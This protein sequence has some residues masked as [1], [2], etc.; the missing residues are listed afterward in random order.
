[1]VNFY[2]ISS[3]SSASST[4]TK[5]EKLVSSFMHSFSH[6][7]I[8]GDKELESFVKLI[9]LKIRSI[10]YVNQRCKKPNCSFRDS[11]RKN[12]VVYIVVGDK[13]NLPIN[14]LNFAGEIK[15]LEFKPYFANELEK[16]QKEQP[17]NLEL[18]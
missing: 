15:S 1:M 4:L 8:I 2:Y 11:Y 14:L 6:H 18:K 16:L 5:V 9:E 10:W 7:L 17:S 12:G 3:P 13:I